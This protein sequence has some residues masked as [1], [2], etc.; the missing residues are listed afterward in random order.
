MWAQTNYKIVFTIAC[1]TNPFG[2]IQKT[3][4]RDGIDYDIGF[5]VHPRR[6]LRAVPGA[7]SFLPCI[8]LTPHFEESSPVHTESPSFEIFKKR[9]FRLAH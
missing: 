7:C 4:K 1:G 8:W 5:G 3:G 9:A 2:I 6:M